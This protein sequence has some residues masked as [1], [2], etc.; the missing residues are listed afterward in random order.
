MT[1]RDFLRLSFCF[2]LATTSA[3]FAAD[4]PQIPEGVPVKIEKQ[5]AN[6]AILE[7]PDGVALEDGV[8][9]K[10]MKTQT[11]KP[12]LPEVWQKRDLRLQINISI[13]Q[14]KG[15][16]QSSTKNVWD[17]NAVFGKNHGKFEWGG[18]LGFSRV[19]VS[20]TGTGASTT[21]EVMTYYGIYGQ[22]NFKENSF[23][24]S[25]IPFIRLGILQPRFTTKLGGTSFV[26]QGDKQVVWLGLDYFPWQV[27]LSIASSIYYAQ[28]KYADQGGG[29]Y[30]EGNEFGFTNGLAWFF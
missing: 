14:T 3:V 28:Y 23:E 4:N 24:N 9:Y 16:I 30:E 11:P 7:L 17:V 25:W 5:K 27:G 22:Y 1:A 26:Y 19:G 15:K 2:L 8:Q 21:D 6:K 18:L 20:Y 29:T 10:L 12:V 13:T